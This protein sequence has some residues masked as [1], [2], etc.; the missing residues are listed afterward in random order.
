MQLLPRGKVHETLFWGDLVK[1]LASLHLNPSGFSPPSVRCIPDAA[2]RQHPSNAEVQEGLF[3]CQSCFVLGF[4]G[5]VGF[6]FS[7]FN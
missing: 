6:F 3:V 5:F 4:F 7:F 2:Q 1:K